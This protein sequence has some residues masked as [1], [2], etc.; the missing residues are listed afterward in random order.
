VLK[1][2]AATKYTITIIIIL[3]NIKIAI[4]IKYTKIVITMLYYIGD[5]TD[6]FY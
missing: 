6:Y 3:N 2:T 1:V 5:N 4:A